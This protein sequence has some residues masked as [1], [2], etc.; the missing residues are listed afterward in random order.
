M[1]K[2]DRLLEVGTFI[3][4]FILIIQQAQAV[5]VCDVNGTGVAFKPSESHATFW[6]EPY[7]CI[8]STTPI[9]IDRTYIIISGTPFKVDASAPVDVVINNWTPE[10]WVLGV[11]TELFNFTVKTNYTNISILISFG[12]L[13]DL[14]ETPIIVYKDNKPFFIAKPTDFHSFE[15]NITINSS[16]CFCFEDGAEVVG[17]YKPIKIEKAGE[18]KGMEA[19]FSGELVE[20]TEIADKSAWKIK[21]PTGEVYLVEAPEVDVKKGEKVTVK[22]TI[23]IVD[24]KP[25]VEIDE[26]FIGE[27]EEMTKM[28][29]HDYV[30]MVAGVVTVPVAP[31]A[32][33]QWVSAIGYAVIGL[34]G[35]ALIGL[36]YVVYKRIR[37]GI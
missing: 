21:D 34:V 24:D 8:K 36:A 4:L 32:A 27:M 28:S 23:K 20:V 19:V 6:V 30:V 9:I 29:E 15:G 13:T 22:G 10:N 1:Q 18:Y 35:L 11:G 37:G 31:V 25:V 14:I 26:C 2:I 33:P 7:G 3:F 5:T 16:E 12:N 17:K